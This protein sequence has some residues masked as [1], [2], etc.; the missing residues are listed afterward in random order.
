MTRLRPPVASKTT[1][2]KTPSL[3]SET[4][5][6]AHAAGLE[7]LAF[8]QLHD[9]VLDAVLVSDVVEGADVRMGE[10]GDRLRLSLEPLARLGRG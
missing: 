10:A 3:P 4:G 7:R 8:E 5:R 6:A 1:A 2:L 9:E